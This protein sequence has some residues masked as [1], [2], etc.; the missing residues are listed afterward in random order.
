[1]VAL[2]GSLAVERAGWLASA[3]Q[4]REFVS[5]A[6]SRTTI[7]L[8]DGTQI[9]LGPA[10]RLRVARQFGSGARAVELDGE[11]LLTV[12]HDPRRPFVVR[13]AHAVVRDVGTT[14]MVRAYADDPLERI[15]VSEG[16]VAVADVGLGT[17]DAASIDGVG[18]VTVRR[19]VDLAADLAWVRGGLA[20]TDAPLRDVVRELARTYG[21]DVTIADTVLAGKLVT[22]S[23]GDEP[24][25]AVLNVVTLAVGAHYER[26]GPSV[27]IRS[28]IAPASRRERTREAEM[29]FARAATPSR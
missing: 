15:V 9:V 18:H 28:G 8:R 27:V 1:M 23:F 16:Q 2:A 29:R 3:P 20:F 14:F 13:T 22:A 12:V 19:G 24:I 17:H 25:D 11:A 7:T 10:T 26:H 21:V 4:F 5:A 6:K